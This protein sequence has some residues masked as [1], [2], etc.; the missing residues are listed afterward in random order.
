MLMVA[1]SRAILVIVAQPSGAET[2]AIANHESYPETRTISRLHPAVVWSN[3][4]VH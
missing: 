4:G 3:L 1:P 2:R